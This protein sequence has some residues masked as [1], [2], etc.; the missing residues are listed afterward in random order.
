MTVRGWFAGLLT[1]AVAL[2]VGAQTLADTAFALKGYHIGMALDQCPGPSMQLP[3]MPGATHCRIEAETLGGDRITT[4]FV[5][6]WN[7]QVIALGALLAERGRYAGN[8]LV[9]ALTA[10]YGQPDTTRAHLNRYVW[11]RGSQSMAFDGYAGSLIASDTAAM[12]ELRRLAAAR[13]KS[14]L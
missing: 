5:S 14:D 3:N 6:L 4:A 10:Q 2:P 12:A 13:N 8:A 1:C 7:G 11:T 9:G